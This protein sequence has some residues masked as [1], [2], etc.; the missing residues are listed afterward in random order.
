MTVCIRIGHSLHLCV[1]DAAANKRL[2]MSESWFLRQL[3]AFS[4][5]RRCGGRLRILFAIIMNGRLNW[6]WTGEERR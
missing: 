6:N 2:F 4:S 1:Y 5:K 3:I